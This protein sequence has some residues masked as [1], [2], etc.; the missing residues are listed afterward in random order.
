MQ[1]WSVIVMNLQGIITRI[2]STLESILVSE[3]KVWA[4]FNFD[5]MLALG[6]RGNRNFKVREFST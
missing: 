2:S 3:T 5:L 1:R 6:I 4:E